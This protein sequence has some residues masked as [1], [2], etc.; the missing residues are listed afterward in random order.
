MRI[1]VVNWDC[2]LPPNTFF[3]SY[4]A[5]TLSFKKWRTRVPYYADIISEDNVCCHLRTADEFDVELQ[6]AIDASIDYFAYVWHTDDKSAKPDPDVKTSVTWP[7]AWTQD[8]ARKLHRKSALNKRIKLCAILLCSQPYVE[9]DYASLAEEMKEEY[10]EKVDGRPLVYLF[11]GYRTDV[12]DILRGFREKYNTAEP[13][14]V[15]M[16]NGVES[17]DGDYSKA[18]AVSAYH[19]N[20]N[21]K[22]IATYAELL[23]EQIADNEDRKKY[24]I[25]IIPSFTVGWNPLP[26]IETVGPW[27]TYRQLIYS[28]R[29][30]ASELEAGTKKLAAWIREN[31]V[32]V[33]VDHILTFAWNE[34]EEGGY[35]CPTYREDGSIDGSLVDAFAKAAE[36]LRSE[37]GGK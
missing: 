11:G 35:I 3:G 24:G 16:N 25:N 36:I 22:N 23:D 19:C 34:F 14:I 20:G 4:F 9:S 32:H 15:F 7:H 6:Y 1:G 27:V 5:K 17:S 33:K 8:Y 26:R 13:Y 30:S 28:E 12:I 21:R 31:R 18:D 37:S 2:S 10:Y 29:A